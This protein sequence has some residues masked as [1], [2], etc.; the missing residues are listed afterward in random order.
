M[1]ELGYTHA[2]HLPMKSR[3][4][5]RF[6]GSGELRLGLLMKSLINGF[7]C[8][9]ISLQLRNFVLHV[10]QQLHK[11]LGISR[12]VGSHI[13]V[14]TMT[15]GVLQRSAKFQYTQNTKLH[16]ELQ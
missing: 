11:L 13:D 4:Q 2:V 16:T 10:L 5:C 1:N 6:H 3:Q 15:R 7:L 12:W 9:Q 8:V 14:S